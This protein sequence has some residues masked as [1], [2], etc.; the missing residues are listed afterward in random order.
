MYTCLNIPHLED[1]LR[2]TEGIKPCVLSISSNVDNSQYFHS[3]K[4]ITKSHGSKSKTEDTTSW[5]RVR[6]CNFQFF[7]IL[8]FNLSLV[9]LQDPILQGKLAHMLYRLSNDFFAADFGDY[10]RCKIMTTKGEKEGDRKRMKKKDWLKWRA[11]HLVKRKD[12]N[13]FLHALTEMKNWLILTRDLPPIRLLDNGTFSV[14]EDISDFNSWYSWVSILLSWLSFSL[15]VWR[16]S[17]CLLSMPVKTTL[18]MGWLSRM[19]RRKWEMRYVVFVWK[20][21]WIADVLWQPTEGNSV[22]HVSNLSDFRRL[23]SL[24][25]SRKFPLSV[26]PVAR[27]HRMCRVRGT[28]FIYPLFY[29]F[30]ICHYQLWLFPE[31]FKAEVRA[32][33][34][35][36][37]F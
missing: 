31:L 21:M 26:R 15:S 12:Q 28:G 14:S 18:P 1:V 11:E 27:P 7:I 37:Q 10:T 30:S 25:C 13:K 3:E 19:R 24:S 20:G 17:I 4:S 32:S 2:S 22:I 35:V 36:F 29:V 8:H 16:P 5:V 6:V 9:K 33:W 23:Y 34:N